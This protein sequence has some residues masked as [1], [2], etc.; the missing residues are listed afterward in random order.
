M[1][2]IIEDDWLNDLVQDVVIESPKKN[3]SISVARTVPPDVKQQPIIEPKTPITAARPATSNNITPHPNASK[4]LR[5][6][7]SAN[8]SKAGNPSLGIR[9]TRSIVQFKSPVM[10]IPIVIDDEVDKNDVTE[11]TD[12]IEDFSQ[13]VGKHNPADEGL[14]ANVD[15]VQAPDTIRPLSP[16]VIVLEAEK[17][18]THEKEDDRP[19]S[20]TNT[21]SQHTPHS[22]PSR[23]SIERRLRREE[24]KAALKSLPRVLALPHV[25]SAFL[26]AFHKN[27]T[28]QSDYLERNREQ[29]SKSSPTPAPKACMVVQPSNAK[30]M[31]V[32][33]DGEDDDISVDIHNRCISSST[34]SQLGFEFSPPIVGYPSSGSSKR[35]RKPPPKRVRFDDRVQSNIY[36]RFDDAEANDEEQIEEEAEDGHNTIRTD[37]QTGFSSSEAGDPENE[38]DDQH[39]I[40]AISNRSR[41]VGCAF[42]DDRSN[43]LCVMEDVE[44]DDAYSITKL[45]KFQINPAVVLI[46][47]RADEPFYEAV[48]EGA[49]ETIFRPGPDFAGKTA[50][51]R[52]LSL[53]VLGSPSKSLISGLAAAKKAEMALYL[54]SVL[55]TNCE[56]MI[57]SAGA[58]ICWMVGSGLRSGDGDYDL[59]D[60]SVEKI[61]QFKLSNFMHLNMDAFVSLGIFSEEL[62]PSMHSRRSREG[63]SLFGIMDTTRTAPGR[64]LLRNWFLRPALDLDVLQERHEAIAYFVRPDMYHVSETLKSGLKQI[65]NMPRILQRI[66]SRLSLKE[67]ESLVKFALSSIKIKAF[68]EECGV[69]SIP[70]FRRVEEAIVEV[71][72]KE[73]GRYITNVIDFDEPPNEGHVSVK[74][75]IDEAL[76]EMKRTYAGLNS[77]LSQVAVRVAATIPPQFAA[78]LNVIYFPQLGFLTTIPKRPE[79]QQPDDFCIEGLEFQ[80]STAN[81]VFYKSEEMFG[82]DETLGDVHSNIVDRENE[83][84][85][86]LQESVLGF[87][88]SILIASSTLAELDCLIAMADAARRY[89]YKQPTVTD[90]DRIEVVRGR[91]P[92]QELCV[93]TFVPNSTQMCVPGQGPRCILLTGANFS[94]KSIYLK[95]I[96]LITY[97]AHIGSFVPAD[98]AI[99]GLTDRIMTRIQTRESV[100][101]IQSAFLIDLQQVSLMLRHATPKSLLIIDEF[102]KGTLSADGVGLFCSTL[103]SL[104]DKGLECPKVVAATHFHEIYAHG[105]LKHLNDPICY[106]CAMEIIESDHTR[107][108]SP[109]S[110]IGKV[111]EASGGV[112]F[113]Y[114]VIRGHATRSLGAHCARLAGI[115][116]HVVERGVQAIALLAQQAGSLIDL[117]QKDASKERVQVRE[118]AVSRL[119]EFAAGFDCLKDDLNELFEEV[120]L[121][122]DVL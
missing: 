121:V 66:K 112:T 31:I 15:P 53:R 46:S 38:Q 113:L 39:V 3:G 6:G 100:S 26:P 114:R 37:D 117:P 116:E 74:Q 23:Y 63:L 89:N 13:D 97:M 29:H 119:V 51:N 90:E 40:M 98:D 58:L 21:E 7:N 44:E 81:T 92:L 73:A 10:A 70:V 79:M 75:G 111:S 109:S 41:K 19:P 14:G 49:H 82:L 104:M 65:K 48:R 32:D 16:S 88:E 12:E 76:D 103:D 20:A 27:Q 64:A 95:Q 17:K 78:S 101:R 69:D 42:Y 105:L 67:W 110:A 71:D 118:Q 25:A 115:P 93:D 83:I 77:L 62:H 22:Q 57:A 60:F 107:H 8:S 5:G 1:D 80:F 30:R 47:S 50:R 84:V 61:E 36:E 68:I 34:S 122:T 35:C 102:G 9:R 11:K 43:I 108:R 52:L 87:S 120:D 86:Q 85:Q 56:N 45:L 54:E 59:S 99:I 33:E 72:L 18:S 106:N 96:A 4:L 24:A 2:S 94:G 91:H 28:D 55:D